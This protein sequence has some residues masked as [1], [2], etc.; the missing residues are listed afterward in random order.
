MSERWQREV[1]QLRDV[2]PGPEVWD[3]A[4]TRTPH[5]DDGLPPTRH[6]LIAGAVAFAVFIGAG[7]FAWQAFRPGDAQEPTKPARETGNAVAITCTPDGT[8]VPPTAVVTNQGPRFTIDNQSNAAQVLIAGVSG[9]AR[10]HAADL[11]PSKTPTHTFD[12]P[13]GDY[14]VGCFQ[15]RVEG[16]G[17][18]DSWSGL[19]GMVPVSILDPEGTYV[20][21]QLMCEG[22]ADTSLGF[23][24][25]PPGS[26][27]EQAIRGA[28]DGI[29][30]SDVI[31]VTGYPGNQ[32][33]VGSRDNISQW[34]IVRGGSSLALV[35]LTTVS[36]G[37]P[38]VVDVTAC[39][40]SGIEARP[41]SG[42]SPTPIGG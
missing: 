33:L 8:E 11:D 41:P 34:R 29:T 15:E 23:T 9:E 39:K 3:D 36:D 10:Q 28:T 18:A 31:E 21:L 30:D 5:G 26:T 24:D 20:S 14:V 4:H 42:P 35:M 13:P 17:G 40:G 7:L 16:A 6:R 38:V 2:E 12:L 1:R 32:G 37:D 22:K 25:V 27:P 19:P